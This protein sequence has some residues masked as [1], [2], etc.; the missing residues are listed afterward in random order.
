MKQIF[1]DKFGDHCHLAGRYRVSI[2]KKCNVN[3][4]Q[5]RSLFIPFLIHKIIK[6]DCHKIFKNLVDKKMIN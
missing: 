5:K 1:I 4:T 3:V 6:Y 2:L